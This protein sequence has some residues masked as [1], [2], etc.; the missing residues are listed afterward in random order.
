LLL[1]GAT[2]REKLELDVRSRL[3][4]TY[5]KGFKAIGEFYDYDLIML[6]A[7]Q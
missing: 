5:R 4:F 2:E 1:N 7:F 3:F 6:M